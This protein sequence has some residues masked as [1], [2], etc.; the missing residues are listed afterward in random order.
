M[1]T[2]SHAFKSVNRQLVIAIMMGISAPAFAQSLNTPENQGP[3]SSNHFVYDEQPTVAVYTSAEAASAMPSA[4]AV[5]A[6]TT[7]I[8]DVSVWDNTAENHLLVMVVNTVRKNLTAIVYDMNGNRVMHET[9]IDPGS[10]RMVEHTGNLKRGN[11]FL[12]V[13]ERGKTIEKVKFTVK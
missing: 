12:H 2:L 7:E 6:M 10:Y 5:D 4:L 9:P 1:K 8:T 3:W 13:L 11:Y